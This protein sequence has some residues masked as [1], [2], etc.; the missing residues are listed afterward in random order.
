MQDR[1]YELPR[2]YLPGTSVNEA[3]AH[4]AFPATAAALRVLLRKARFGVP[5]GARAGG[6]P[7]AHPYDLQASSMCGAAES[8]CPSLTFAL[9]A[10]T[11]PL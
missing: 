1:G 6:L 5:R 8:T 2:I 9:V 7:L 3:L 11:N 10:S 4:G